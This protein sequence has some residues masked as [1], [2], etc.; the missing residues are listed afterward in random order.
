MANPLDFIQ[1]LQNLRSQSR[2]SKVIQLPNKYGDEHTSLD[3]D[4]TYFASKHTIL[5]LTG[6]SVIQLNL[7]KCKNC[8]HGMKWQRSSVN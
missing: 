4:R 3:T 7:K 6:R 2:N 1:L 8:L 5:L